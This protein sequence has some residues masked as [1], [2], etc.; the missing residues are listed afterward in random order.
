MPN[1]II[2]I[3]SPE[4]TWVKE[5]TN[6]GKH[7]HLG[8]MC[9]NIQACGAHFSCKVPQSLLRA[10]EALR[11][12]EWE[13]GFGVRQMWIRSYWLMKGL[14]EL[15]W[16]TACLHFLICEEGGRVVSLKTNQNREEEK[17]GM[18]T[19][20]SIKGTT[21]AESLDVAFRKTMSRPACA[22]GKACHN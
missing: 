21:A 8:T 17:K 1:L 13:P 4:T 5:K 18:S 19:Q 20:S 6:P 2:W 3:W 12:G 16:C 15:M 22:G 14:N 9:S 10:K 11:S 7:Q